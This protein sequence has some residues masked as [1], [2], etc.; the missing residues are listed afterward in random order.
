MGV[1]SAVPTAGP[2]S[3]LEASGRER[4]TRA[5]G[6]TIRKPGVAVETAAPVSLSVPVTAQPLGGWQGLIAAQG[7]R[8]DPG[9]PPL[10]PVLPDSGGTA[11]KPAGPEARQE[12]RR[13]Q[14][15]QKQAPSPQRERGVRVRTRKVPEVE[16]TPHVKGGRRGLR[17][18]NQETHPV[19]R[20][21]SLRHTHKATY[22][23]T[24]GQRGPVP[25]R[26]SIPGR[27]GMGERC[28]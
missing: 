8:P 15:Q 2:V 5:S 13:Q 21:E 1:T 10:H 6:Q 28:L 18:C 12:G 11:S 27:E 23:G 26:L 7:P 20:A 9:L 22:G 4:L 25:R 16:V 19:K 3:T 14:T 24:W 17:S